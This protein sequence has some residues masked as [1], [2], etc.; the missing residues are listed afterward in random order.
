MVDSAP[1]NY[2]ISNRLPLCARYLVVCGRTA[3]WRPSTCGSGDGSQVL[4]AVGALASG[5]TEILGAWLAQDVNRPTWA[6][7]EDDL[8]RRGVERIRVLVTEDSAVQAANFPGSPT[9]VSQLAC[10]PESMSSLGL[11]A[12]QCRIVERTVLLAERISAL[13]RRRLSRMAPINAAADALERVAGSLAQAQRRIDMST[14]IFRGAL[15]RPSGQGAPRAITGQRL[16]MPTSA[17]GMA[18]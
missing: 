16:I 5:E 8:R 10:M 2:A 11:A 9:L 12:R 1:A 4:W 18:R 13:I 14:D 3:S 7:V 17:R 6:P 15:H